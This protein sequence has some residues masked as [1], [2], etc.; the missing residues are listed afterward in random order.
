MR[1][2]TQ[3]LEEEY[4]I[5]VPQA[6]TEVQLNLRIRYIGSELTLVRPKLPLFKANRCGH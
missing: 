6:L 5:M 2:F 1:L 4:I 3:D